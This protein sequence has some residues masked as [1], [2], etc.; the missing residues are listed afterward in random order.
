MV[1]RREFLSGLFSPHGE[2]E[3]SAPSF[4]KPVEPEMAEQR[5]F[6]RDTFT[7]ND[8]RV[9]FYGIV[10]DIKLPE[11]YWKVLEDAI[12][13]ASIVVLE[14][15][16]Q[17]SGL[18]DRSFI[19]KH[20]ESLKKYFPDF[21]ELEDISD[22]EIFEALIREPSLHFYREMEN[23]AARH[24]KR[25]VTIDPHLL[26]HEKIHELYKTDQKADLIKSLGM[27][28]GATGVLL[29]AILRKKLIGEHVRGE[30]GENKKEED[31]SSTY[32]RRRF[33]D[34]T[35]KAGI[36]ISATV[37]ALSTLSKGAQILGHP[38]YGKKLGY[39][40]QF[41]GREENPLGAFLYDEVDFKD[42]MIAK[43]MDEVTQHMHAEDEEAAM[44]YGFFHKTG[45]GHYLR[46]PRE[47]AAREQLY[48]PYKG[49]VGPHKLRM[50]EYDGTKEEWRKIEERNIT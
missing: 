40:D 22:Q 49:A 20:R 43:G 23:L 8:K 12:Q 50:Y 34:T 47:R 39:D 25:I 18:Y 2:E 33:L 38:E 3:K 41:V 32:T 19:A 11:R 4:E 6:E 45:I 31:S 36:G 21:A 16:P 13:R 5:L 48:A 42:V 7:I 1:T 14:Y 30:N 35:L 28:G 44:I 9:E 46:S 37:G 26:A 24:K 17:A 10:H 29:S 27:V 15:A